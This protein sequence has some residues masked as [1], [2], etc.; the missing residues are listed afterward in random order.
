MEEN[1]FGTDI[2]K[3]ATE[4]LDLIFRKSEQLSYGEL[5]RILAC[6]RAVVLEFPITIPKTQ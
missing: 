5:E 1:L 3:K 2:Y 6:M 4:A